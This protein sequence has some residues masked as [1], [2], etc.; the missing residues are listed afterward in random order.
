MTSAPLLGAAQDYFA[1][2]QEHVA[3]VGRVFQ[4]VKQD[5]LDAPLG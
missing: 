4:Q 1:A 5:R 2:R 3:I